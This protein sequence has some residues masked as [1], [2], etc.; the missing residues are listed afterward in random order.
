YEPL[1]A[2]LGPEQEAHGFLCASLVEAVR[3]LPAVAE[4]AD[5]N[6]E[7]VR[8]LMRGRAGSCVFLG[9]SWGGVLAYETARR[10]GPDCPLDWVGMLDACA[11]EANFAPGAGRP[12]E[13]AERAA[14]EALVEA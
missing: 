1:V 14:H 3:P 5:A 8:D 11:L 13:P 7:R 6:A 9:W 2:H 10:L 12:I 4:L